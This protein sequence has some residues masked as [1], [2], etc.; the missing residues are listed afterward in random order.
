MPERH[1]GSWV[2]LVVYGLIR[3][4]TNCLLFVWR[5]AVAGIV[6]L[7]GFFQ[8][9]LKNRIIAVTFV[10]LFAAGLPMQLFQEEIMTGVDMTYECGI[11]PTVEFLANAFPLP[12]MRVPWEVMSVEYNNIALALVEGI[13]DLFSD[14]R[15]LVRVGQLTSVKS[16]LST[17]SLMLLDNELDGLVDVFNDLAAG[18]FGYIEGLWDFM[19]Y[20]LS[21]IVAIVNTVFIKLDFFGASCS[22]C[23]ADPLPA[24]G[25]RQKIAPHIANYDCDACHEHVADIFGLVGAFADAL[26]GNSVSGASNGGTSFTRIFRALGCVVRSM[27]MYPMHILDASALAAT[28]YS[29]ETLEQIYDITDTSSSVSRWFLAG[30]PTFYNC[31]DD[32][33]LCC[34]RPSGCAFPSD[35]SGPGTDLPIGIAPC[36]GELFRALTN[37]AVDDWLEVVLTFLAKPLMLIV[38]TVSRA[39]ECSDPPPVP[40]YNNATLSEC[41]A[42]YRDQDCASSSSSNPGVCAYSGSDA[43]PT[44]G[45]HVCFS[46]I[47]TC[48]NDDPEKHAPLLVPLLN[49]GA[50][51]TSIIEFFLVDMF[52]YTVDFVA[53]PFVTLGCCMECNACDFSEWVDK[54]GHVETCSP[55]WWDVLEWLHTLLHWVDVHVVVPLGQ[56]KTSVASLKIAMAKVAGVLE[57]LDHC[58]EGTFIPF[59][60]DGVCS[61]G[62]DDI[63]ELIECLGGKTGCDAGD[64]LPVMDAYRRERADL[65]NATLPPDPA[66]LAT[67]CT[68]V[69]DTLGVSRGSICNE[70]LCSTTPRR[71]A[72][73]SN[74]GTYIGYHTCLSLYGGRYK[75]AAD[76]SPG[77]ATNKTATDLGIDAYGY[78]LTDT[79]YIMD[80]VCDDAGR[81]RALERAS[82]LFH[83]VNETDTPTNNTWSTAGAKVFPQK[84]LDLLSANASVNANVTANVWQAIQTTRLYARSAEFYA[85]YNAAAGSGINVT[86]AT[87]ERLDTLFADYA[88]DVLSLYHRKRFRNETDANADESMLALDEYVAPATGAVRKYLTPA[89]MV[90]RR[91][92]VFAKMTELHIL[93][94]DKPTAAHAA[95][96]AATMARWTAINDVLHIEHRPWF[97]FAAGVARALRTR[98]GANLAGMLSG[99]TKYATSR[100][101]FITAGRF[102]KE[103]RD[104]TRPSLLDIAPGSGI[105]RLVAGDDTAAALKAARSARHAMGTTWNARSPRSYLPFPIPRP[106]E[107]E[108]DW[109]EPTPGPPLREQMWSRMSRSNTKYKTRRAVQMAKRKERGL[110]DFNANQILYDGVDWF[111][112]LFSIGGV[113]GLLN[114]LVANTMVFWEEFDLRNFTEESVEQKITDF[115]RCDIPENIN[116]TQLH[117]PFCVGLLRED[118]FALFSAVTDTEGQ[119]PPQIPWPADL[120]TQQCETVYNGE[121]ADDVFLFDFS[122]N[123]KLP[124]PK[125]REEVC[126]ESIGSCAG[127][128]ALRAAEVAVRRNV[129]QYVFTQ[130]NATCALATAAFYVPT[131]T[132]ITDVASILGNMGV[133]A[134][135][136]VTDFTI[137][138]DASGAGCEPGIPE[139]PAGRAVLRLAFDLP[140]DGICIVNVTF[141][142][143]IAFAS[144]AS[145]VAVAGVGEDA[146]KNCS[147]TVPTK[148]CLTSGDTLVDPWAELRPFCD[149][150]DYCEREYQSCAD[151]GFGDFLHT[152]LY[153]TGHIPLVGDEALYGGIDVKIVENWIGPPVVIIGFFTAAMPLVPLLCIGLPLCLTSWAV[154]INITHVFTWSLLVFFGGLLPYPVL[155]FAAAM[156]AY[157]PAGYEMI[158]LGIVIVM[159]PGI[160]FAARLILA[161]LVFVT[162]IPKVKEFVPYIIAINSVLLAAWLLSLVFTFPHLSGVLNINQA[163]SDVLV[164]M[165]DSIFL[166][167]LDVRPLIARVSAFIYPTAAAVPPLHTF[168]FWWNWGNLA[169]L[170]LLMLFAIWPLLLLFRWAFPPFLLALESLW[171]A[172]DMRRRVIAVQMQTSVGTLEGTSGNNKSRFHALRKSS[173]KRFGKIKKKFA[174]KLISSFG[175]SPDAVPTQRTQLDLG[176]TPAPDESHQEF[177]E[178]RTDTINSAMAADHASDDDEIVADGDVRPRRRRMLTLHRE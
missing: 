151:A 106:L 31:N 135:E 142:S 60:A 127:I 128:L 100:G 10:G 146:C 44:G 101:A 153:M 3:L 141:A 132:D 23:S 16:G 99:S 163:L 103:A 137:S 54:L 50:S 104:A 121:G 17:L 39:I 45:I 78:P 93:A 19:K 37:D 88:N 35:A 155:F 48:L 123:C 29:C 1:I 176:L 109:F 125:V 18:F 65:Y 70:V 108:N 152:F 76:C 122:N 33:Q 139:P 117:S 82:T 148:T 102:R 58:Y 86:N 68:Y 113:E 161:V 63:V 164:V 57:C 40:A 66:K 95:I 28:P 85:T 178:R 130:T 11:Y 91:E 36:V 110:G 41:L 15:T 27:W 62:C 25:L 72:K 92:D 56:L 69:T 159:S 131:C 156:Y 81:K 73:S 13:D 4:L 171:L 34:G 144:G 7:R 133:N 160:A 55:A 119:F 90:A 126:A 177:R 175:A 84:I 24:C 118:A 120:I 61:G 26:V 170:A 14:M 145:A 71:A 140:L 43:A 47:Y 94:P 124:A 64:E 116:G 46:M 172:F 150:C 112:G 22:L 143:G 154:Y 167:W 166:F 173:K 32:P 174:R 5:A 96:D 162:R 138:T 98:D 158:V 79:Q 89:R 53:C 38:K 67:W 83:D 134:P 9:L 165:D 6:T 168:C 74:F 21:I 49:S 30:D 169:L 114:G 149:T 59:P 105:T 52:R 157:Y 97:Q 80:N 147:L 129:V 75:L 2:L 12:V 115:F 107:G 51:G 42:N 111:F 20:T 136:C 87:Q 77:D 8:A